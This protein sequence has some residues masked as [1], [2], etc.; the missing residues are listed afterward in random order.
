MSGRAIIFITPVV[1]ERDPVPSR[2]V[3][4][5]AIFF[6]SRPEGFF[7][8][9]GISRDNSVPS[10]ELSVPSRISHVIKKIFFY[11]S[12]NNTA[13]RLTILDV[14]FIEFLYRKKADFVVK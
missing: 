5:K 8:I 6:P 1:M 11:Y 10:R 3:P 4:G 9:P 14:I 2:P 13:A 12:Q 7:I